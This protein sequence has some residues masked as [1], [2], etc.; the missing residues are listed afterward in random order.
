MFTSELELSI[1]SNRTNLDSA[2]FI[3]F[4]AAD[5]KDLQI[6]APAELAPPVAALAHDPAIIAVSLDGSKVEIMA[7]L[8]S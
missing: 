6:E 4:R 2:S 5:V 3:V 8:S 1:S 7:N